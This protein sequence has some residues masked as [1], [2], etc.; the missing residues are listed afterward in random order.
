MR[1]ICREEMGGVYVY[2]SRILLFIYG[3]FMGAGF[4][5]MMTYNHPAVRYGIIAVTFAALIIKRKAV[6]GLVKQMASLRKAKK[7]S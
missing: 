6:A 1:K 3:I 2:D 7:K 5:L 4:L